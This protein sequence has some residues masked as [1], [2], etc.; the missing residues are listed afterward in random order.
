[1]VQASFLIPGQWICARDIRDM[2]ILLKSKVLPPLILLHDFD[3]LL[4]KFINII[5]Y[6]LT[7]TQKTAG[8][9]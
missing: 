9:F 2:N 1:M 3:M 6:C 7:L 5:T 4:D 8:L